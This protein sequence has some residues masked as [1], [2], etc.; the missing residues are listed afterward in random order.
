MKK[1]IKL[2]VLPGL[3]MIGSIA[4]AQNGENG[5]QTAK[6]LV[7]QAKKANEVGKAKP[8]SSLAKVH[9][10]NAEKKAVKKQTINSNK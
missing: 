7:Q 6:P 1:T 3:L 9:V 2:L 5:K 4:F 10:A 8:A